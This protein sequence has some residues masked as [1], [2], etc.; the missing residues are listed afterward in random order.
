MPPS[1]AVPRPQDAPVDYARPIKVICIGAG[2]SGIL[3]G[4]RFS[5]RIQNLDL[6]IYDKNEDF[7]GVWYENR[8][9]G[10]TCDVPSHAYQ[11]TFANNPNWSHFFSPGK[12]IGNYFRDVAD[13]YDVRKLVRFGHVFRAA[14]WLEEQT[15]W[16]ITVLRLSDNVELKEYCDVFVK[17]TGTLNKWVWPS[18]N[19]LHDFKGN[20]LHSAKWDESFDP[21]GKRVAVIGCGSTGLQLVPA[22]LG[23]VKYM[24]HYVRGPSWISPAGYVAADPRKA[25]SDVHNFEHP[26]EEREEFAKDPETYLRYRHQVEKYVNKS[27]GLHVLGTEMNRNFTKATEESMARR[28]ASKPEILKHMK[29]TYPV[30]C[31]RV[32]PGP[33]Y[34]ECLVEDNLNFIPNGIKRVTESG[35]ED[36][37]GTFR[38]V[39]AIVCATGFDT[40]L[41]HNENPIYGQNDVSLD[42]LWDSEPGAYMSICPPQMP[43]LFLFLGPNGTA[44][45]GSTIQ[46]SECACEYMIKCVQKLQRENLR[47][48]VPKDVAVRAFMK[49]VDR[50]FAKTTFAFMCGQWA[51]RT[52]NGRVLGYWPGGAVHQRATLETPRFEDFEYG[53]FD[54]D[55]EDCLAWMGNG[56]IVAQE[57]DTSTTGYLDTVDVPPLPRREET[58]GLNVT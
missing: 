11:Y 28:L 25:N 14:R 58:G 18:I 5:Q 22:I 41:R 43:N 20:L 6:T 1:S 3:C 55:E 32:S 45:A 37:T 13:R 21:T 56:M 19:G 2:M 29:P 46:M 7:G 9:P 15:R 52:P 30:A 54:E 39:D 44:G 12:E 49:Q 33:R 40:S 35:I 36:D 26:V 50:Y 38:E 10:V 42:Q 47:W 4:I 34:L 16:E 23:K 8:Y 51:K 24:D 17:A 57:K 48:M 53:S 27:Q 31:R